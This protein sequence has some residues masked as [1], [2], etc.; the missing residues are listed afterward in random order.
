MFIVGDLLAVA[1]CEVYRDY[2]KAAMAEIIR[3]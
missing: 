2:I 1:E 3:K